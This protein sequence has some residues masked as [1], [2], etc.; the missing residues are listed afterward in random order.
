MINA[1]ARLYILGEVYQ[2]QLE[3]N[4]RTAVT[5]VICIGRLIAATR[6]HVN[7]CQN[8]YRASQGSG[9][10]RVRHPEL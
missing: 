3:I 2:L 9:G 10:D 1:G 8:V 5:E 7:T 4:S 6:E